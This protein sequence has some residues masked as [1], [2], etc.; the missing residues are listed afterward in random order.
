MGAGAAS[1]SVEIISSYRAMWIELPLAAASRLLGGPEKQL[2]TAAWRAYDSWVALANEATNRLYT[3]RAFADLSALLF[4]AT[5]R[6][7]RA[8]G[9]LM[10]T[11][12]APQ[13]PE[14]PP[15]EYDG[16]SRMASGL[17]RP[18]ARPSKRRSRRTAIQ[19][20]ADTAQNREIDRAITA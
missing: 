1:L 7:Q 9:L 20:P 10:G 18:A 4:E 8:S 11:T 17:T 3:N 14:F 5:L 15:A 12:V 2:G 16:P 19:S 6:W 13:N